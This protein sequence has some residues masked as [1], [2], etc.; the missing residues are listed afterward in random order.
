[1]PSYQEMTFTAASANITAGASWQKLVYTPGNDL[2]GSAAGGHQSCVVLATS[3]QSS[4]SAT[5]A[6]RW[7][8]KN[9]SLDC[10][11]QDKSASVTVTTTRTD[12][13]GDSGN[14][15]CTVAFDDGSNFVDL[16]PQGQ[17]FDIWVGCSALTTITSLAVRVQPKRVTG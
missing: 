5:I 14:Y 17:E 9:Q 8:L 16:A 3:N 4:G 13:D 7:A 15:I 12:L 1:M 6:F 11:W 10:V 2:P